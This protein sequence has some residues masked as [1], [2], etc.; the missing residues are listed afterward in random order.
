MADTDGSGFGKFVPGFEFMQNLARQAAGGIA[1]G[2][3]QSVPQLPSLNS[4]VAPT[5]S[6]EELEKRIAE[7]K[8]VQFWLDQN[9]RALSATVQAL[10]VQKMTL[11]TLQGMNVNLGDVANALKVRATDTMTTMAG[12]A[13]LGSD[14]PKEPTRFKGL[15]VPPRT[16][17]RESA[18][19]PAPAAA[20]SAAV[21][22]ML[23]W[24]S[25]SQQFQNIATQAMKDVATQAALDT[26]RNV[27]ASLTR[28]AVKTATQAATAVAQ[29]AVQAGSGLVGAGV[30]AAST[31]A[32]VAS[33]AKAKA[34]SVGAVAA[35]ATAK[36]APK[37]A[38]TRT[39]AKA[40][41]SK[42]AKSAA[43]SRPRSR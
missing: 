27:A 10:E 23:W 20:A 39:S 30:R 36:A 6:V 40:A 21:D 38:A 34:A 28:E 32:K 1:Q 7:L 18:P 29:T 12:M 5:F 42:A 3:Q 11:A 25:L 17:A 33:K 37:A 9:A 26:S 19:A 4:W 8:A 13:G 2:V 41:P 16:G 35:P 14:A 43:A 15:E 31:G 22:P 24:G